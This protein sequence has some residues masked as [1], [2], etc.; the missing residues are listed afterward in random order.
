MTPDPVTL[1]HPASLAG[2]G[3]TELDQRVAE[4]TALAQAYVSD[5]HRARRAAIRAAVD[6][7]PW[8]GEA[9]TRRRL[10]VRAVAERLGISETQ[11]Y[12]AMRK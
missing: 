11:V 5:L 3:L 7:E 8:A 9:A 12:Q 4:L 10:R 1:P 2:L 6:D